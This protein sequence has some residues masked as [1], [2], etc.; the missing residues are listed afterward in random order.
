MLKNI[1]NFKQKTKSY[2]NKKT[3]RYVMLHFITPT[4]AIFMLLLGVLW[5]DSYCLIES[6]KNNAVEY[7]RATSLTYENT[8]RSMNYIAEIANGMPRI[9]E[10]FAGTNTGYSPEL[11]SE[12]KS[13][14]DS[15]TY[16]NSIFIMDTNNFRV[17]TKNGVFNYDDFFSD[18]YVYDNYNCAYWK[19]PI[20]YHTEPYRTLSPCY[21][22]YDNARVAVVPMVFKKIGTVNSMNYLLVNIDLNKIMRQT[23][24]KATAIGKYYM[25]NRYT[26]ELFNLQSDL[27]DIPDELF[28]SLFLKKL[29]ETPNGSFTYSLPS[30][31]V[32][33]S[34]YSTNHS[35]MGYTYLSI[36]PVKSV[37]WNVTNDKVIY[38]ILVLLGIIITF[39]ITHISA[40]RI[41]KP[42]DY[43]E[44]TVSY[45]GKGGYKNIMN[46]FIKFANDAAL[47]KQQLNNTLPYIKERY[48]CSYLNSTEHYIDDSLREQL[49][50]AVSFPNKYFAVMLIQLSPTKKMFD[51]FNSSEYIQIKDGFYNVVKALFMEKFTCYVIPADDDSLDVILNLEN[52]S[53]E[54]VHD[55]LS[56]I[57]ELLQNDLAYAIMS[58]GVS[59]IHSELAGLKKAHDEAKDKFVPYGN[60]FIENNVS[61]EIS[62]ESDVIFN[63]DDENDLFL[64]FI[65]LDKNKIDSAI[66]NI[67]DKNEPLTEQGTKR[68]YNHLIST[69]L[70]FA[71]ANNISVKSD[72]L[73]YEIISEMLNR[74]I[75]EMSAELDKLIDFIIDTHSVKHRR[76]TD[77]TNYIEN[78]WGNPDLSVKLLADEF[79]VSTSSVSSIVKNNTGMGVREFINHLRIEHAKQ[80][81]LNDDIDINKICE[82]CG[83][84]SRQTFFRVFKNTVGLTSTEYRTKYLGK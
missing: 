70:R 11:A 84:V 80:M 12:L 2:Y 19:T 65:S 48:L 75:S 76:N 1:F 31:K 39:I 28:D 60:D 13:I 38:I 69:A 53:F 34:T 67:T 59:T 82:E 29:S 72:K 7:E 6:E 55:V 23:S 61:L 15:Y 54:S 33:V 40:G 9:S 8:L 50:R 20:I 24:V 42:I 37:V 66:R 27:N 68:L 63:S 43:I 10:T 18:I 83:F 16:I 5:Y 32:I 79:K 17:Y 51:I 25:H 30:G 46:D 4:V 78:N 56:Q 41:Y 22:N 26:N 3:Y 49:A 73:D 57:Y 52:D 77:I 35:I 74:P 62:I 45:S 58:V 14:T 71:K 44:K 21:V 64:A 36:I 81:L 47:A